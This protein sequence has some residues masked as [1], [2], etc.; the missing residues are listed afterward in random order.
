MS[1]SDTT[2]SPELVARAIAKD[3]DA[4]RAIVRAMGPVIQG[5]VAKALLRRRGRHA[6][7]VTQE[8]ADFTQ[9]IFLF[10]FDQDGKA[11]CAWDPQRGPLGA[12][13]A[14]IAD[15]HVYSAFRS[16]KKRPWSDD[17]DVLPEYELPEPEGPHPETR[18]ASRQALETL[19]ERLRAELSPKGF[20]LFVR[21]YVEEQPVEAI[22]HDLAMTP[23]ALYMW[24][25][26]LS[27]MARALMRE[28]DG[29]AMSE[30]SPLLRTS[31]MGQP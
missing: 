9:E 27:K 28:L 1:P 25:S 21:L 20:D 4:V 5:R 30:N 7:D 12:F 24:R 2:P 31:S 15:H 17:L 26:R 23:E 29:Q 22:S 14:L 3:A 16:G 19:L 6:R 18:M 13:V 10:L 8:I 11:L